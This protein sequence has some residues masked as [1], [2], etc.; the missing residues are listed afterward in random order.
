MAKAQDDRGKIM[1]DSS[2]I[3]GFA[4]GMLIMYVTGLMVP[5]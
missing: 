5:S 1:S 2:I 3:A 4:A